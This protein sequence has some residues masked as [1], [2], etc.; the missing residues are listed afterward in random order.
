MI[1]IPPIQCINPR[2]SMKDFGML[3][4]SE[5]TVAPVAVIPDIDSNSA[6]IGLTNT[7]DII[8]G[9]APNNI[10][11]IHVELTTKKP[12]LKLKVLLLFP[13]STSRLPSSMDNIAV[14]QKDQYAVSNRI[15]YINGITRKA[16][17]I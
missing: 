11:K 10:V 8:K 14:I 13:P 6:S 9:I 15:L 17:K 1:P 3:S 16:P 7:P 12:S 2:H 4:T 5:I